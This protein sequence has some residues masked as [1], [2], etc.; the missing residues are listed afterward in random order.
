MA[1]PRSISAL[2]SSAVGGVPTGAGG[3]SPLS[4]AFAPPPAPG[5]SLAP[6]T[7]P[8]PTSPGGNPTSP[9]PI[10]PSMPQI[11]APNL[12]DVPE[13]PPMPDSMDVP[14]DL[15]A[16]E[17]ASLGSS[18]RDKINHAVQQ[19]RDRDERIRQWRDQYEAVTFPKNFPWPNAASLNVP[20]TR[21]ITD[22]VVAI[23]MAAMTDTTPLVRVEAYPGAP[24][25]AI[26][27]MEQFI[28]WQAEE[29]LDL[30]GF[31]DDIM[32]P[33][34]RDGT[35]PC[36]IGWQKYN[37][38]TKRMSLEQGP[39]TGKLGWSLIEEDDYEVNQPVVTPIDVLD[40]FLYPANSRTIK[41]AIGVGDRVWKTANDLRQGVIDGIYDEDSVRLLLDTVPQGERDTDESRGGDVSRA[42]NVGIE[43]AETIDSADHAY[44]LFE[45][46]WKWAKS[47]D[48]VQEDCYFVVDMN[49]GILIRAL[50][51]PFWH[52]ERCYFDYTPLKR[53]QSFYGY[54]IPEILEDLQAEINA[55]RNQRVDAG[56]LLL[57]PVM[58]KRRGIFKDANKQR[59]RPGAVLEVDDPDKDVKILSF[60]T[61]LQTAFSEEQSAREQA[62][63]VT[64][65]SDSAMGASP[66]RS[67][68]LGETEAV[69]AS[70]NIKFKLIVERNHRVSNKILQQMFLL[71]RQYMTDKLEFAISGQVG[72][73]GAI[74]PQELTTRVKISC[75]G[76]TQNGAQQRLEASETLFQMSQVSPLMQHDLGRVWNVLAYRLNAQG[77]TNVVPFIGTEQEAIQKQQQLEQQG[78]PPPEPPALSG[79]L[80][81]PASLAMMFA[82]GTITTEQ[83][84]QAAQLIQQHQVITAAGKSG[85][86]A[87]AQIAARQH[88][89]EMTKDETEH[90]AATD[91]T[92]NLMGQHLQ[93]KAAPQPAPMLPPNGGN[94]AP[95]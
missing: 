39:K 52:G 66:S 85:A 90:A 81:D 43:D 45:C 51:Y 20:I 83:Y 53:P 58:L 24:D 86:D 49:S 44:E 75:Q 36:K 6:G 92:A 5:V 61:M 50:H 38:K 11:S 48:D 26:R 76:N 55:I 29:Q 46:V 74:T 94:A 69:M 70:G 88:E 62:E 30:R 32:L 17:R 8:G 67:R 41:D 4:S 23:V 87:V 18:L 14:L 93:A 16:D 31:W 40:F 19:K 28:N 1:V 91:M 13:V 59:W 22:T 15:T 33:S 37:K 64:G 34:L 68:P 12:P 35:A 79:K 89:S 54:S 2:T 42:A 25:D 71:D 47:E 9:S 72:A 80:D 60:Q 78:P 7:P 95:Q 84:Q 27:N 3:P 73:F 21:S 77:I 57:S 56:T 82:E 63:K 65:V 10:S